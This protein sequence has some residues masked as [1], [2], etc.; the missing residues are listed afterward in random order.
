MNTLP[1]DFKKAYDELNKAQKEAVDTIEGPVMVVAGP[2][3]GKTKI[4]TLRIAKILEKTDSAPESILAL[5]Y[6]TAGVIAMREKLLEIIGDRAYRV[7]IFT[8]HAFCEYL[9]KEFSFY[10]EELGGARVIDDLERVKIIESIIKNNKFKHLVSFHDEFS[11]LNKIVDGILAIKKE[12]LSPKE[13]IDGL[14][15][16]KQELL[17]DD[18]LYYKKDYGEYKKGEIK[19]AEKEKINKKIWKAEEL[20]EIFSLYQI[21]LKNRGLYDF[22]DMILYTRE[23]LLKNKD[24]KADVQER[25][26]YILVD[27]HQDTN[28]GQ[29]T[30]VELLTDALHLEGHP[31]IFTVGDE[32]QSIYRFQGASTETFSRFKNLYKDIKLITLSEN[33]R[34]TQNILDGAHS[35]IIKSKGLED[36]VILH[37]NIKENEKINVREFSNYK[38]ELLFL[39]EDIKEKIKSGIS[40]SEIAVLYRANKNVS[41]I[42]TILDSYQ[43]PYTIFSKDKILDDPNIRNLLNILRVIYNP[44]DDHYLGKVFFINFLN[45]DVYDNIKILDKFRSLRKEAKKH[46][47]AIIDNKEI[48]KEIDVKNQKDFSNLASMIKELKTDSINQNFADFFKIFLDKIGYIRYMLASVDSRIQLL[49]LDKLLDEIKKQT[50]TKKDYNLSDFIY[51]IDS[52]IKYNLDIKTTDP[53]IIEGV[54]LM[55]AHGSKGREFENV[56]I[57][58]ATRKYWEASRGGGNNITLPIYQYDGD[59]EDEKRL[60]YVAM[61][62][63]KKNLSISFSRTDNEG[64]EHEAS[65]FIEEI[66]QLY[67]KEDKMHVFEEKNIDKIA[68]FMNFSKS[69]SSLFEKEYLRKLFFERGLNVTAL[70]N[71]LDC[72]KKYLFKNL[73]RIPDVYSATLS[74]GSTVHKALE[75]FFKNSNKEEK[76]L[77][78]DVLLSEFEK[79]LEKAKMSEK[80]EEK[81]KERGNDILSEYY[82]KYSSAWSYKVKVEFDPK[83]DFELESKEILEL[84]GKI[85]KIEYLNDDNSKEVNLIDYKTG[86]P[87]SE[88]TKEQKIDYERQIVFYHLLLEKYEDDNIVI[89]KS[90]LDFLQKNKKGNFEQYSF[91]VT[92]EHLNKLKK[93]INDLAEDVLSMEFLKKGCHKKDCGWCQIEM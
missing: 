69:R 57:I 72:P 48:L 86:K 22:S 17:A 1:Q 23:E 12:G 67:K 76:I 54:S 44:N 49:K 3:T 35:L 6:T 87:F 13:F 21:E 58:N 64:R 85:D 24:F 46:L 73:I 66:D 47:F 14:P 31:N 93:E 5:T 10:F 88:K 84:T 62:R 18:D 32:K 92:K 11:F 90:I 55:T 59:I 2:G 8:F 74:F 30:L 33:Y 42:K 79:A 39:A 40:P 36:S 43:I 15:T 9:I 25:Y 56:Y 78:K 45:L 75:L 91:D 20:G 82:D 41:D 53:E 7:N 61:T 77:P 19:P 89:N 37:S 65:Q 81:Y 28:E 83:R 29:N 50:E 16:W 4:L 71:Y 80:D 60:F 26:Q 51:F 27:E 70:N 38:F 52:F 68:S 34:S 63:A